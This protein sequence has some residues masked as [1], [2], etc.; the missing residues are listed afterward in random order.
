ML[1]GKRAGEV[2][3]GVGEW[4]WVWRPWTLLGKW[5]S[6]SLG[7][8]LASH[9]MARKT[10]AQCVTLERSGPNLVDLE[11]TRVEHT[12]DSVLGGANLHLLEDDAHNPLVLQGCGITQERC[13][14][15]LSVFVTLGT[16]QRLEP[17]VD[18]GNLCAK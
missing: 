17:L 5:P 3:G 15:A 7:Q 12:Q 9:T 1:M 2:E 11:G 8:L 10:V 4:R 14:E 6:I 13:E 18:L 16:P